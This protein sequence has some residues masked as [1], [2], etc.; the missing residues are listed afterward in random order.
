MYVTIIMA[1]KKGRP[2]RIPRGYGGRLFVHRR[3]PRRRRKKLALKPHSFVERVEDR[4]ALNSSTLQ[5][6]GSLLV[7]YKKTF[8][9]TDIAQWA[10][11]KELFDDYILNKVVL[12]IRYNQ[13]I[14]TYT[15][16]T[17]IVNEIKPLLLIKTDH[18]DA[19]TG[20]SWDDL[21]ASE[22]ARLVQMD[23]GKVVSHVIKPA[24]QKEAYKT[25]VASAYCPSFNVQIRT[26]DDTVPHYGLKIQVQ[27]QPGPAVYDL[28]NLSL[29][30][31]Y[32]FTM[33]NAE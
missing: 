24:V 4:I 25:A 11:Y 2:S 21:K 12:E 20:V 17:P 5:A 8:Q 29:M 7:N 9:M 28:G 10:N 32:Y 18:N 1:R 16:T 19:S 6:N 26:I 13:Q 14:A 3:R 33:K 15:S 30:Y 23:G 31:K 27:T 22:K